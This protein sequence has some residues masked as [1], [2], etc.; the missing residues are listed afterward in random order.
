[1]PARCA[2]TASARTCA[3]CC[4]T[5]RGWIHRRSTCSSA[6]QPT[7]PC[8]EELGENFR[9]IPETAQALLGRANSCGS[10]SICG[11]RRSICFTRRITCCR[12]S[13]RASRSSRFT[14]AS[15]CGFRSTCP[16]RLGY[17]YA[18]SSMWMATHRAN[19]VL[20]VSEASKR[21]ILRYFRVPEKQDRRHLQR[22][23]RA[24]RRDADRRGS[25]ARP[26]ALSAE[27][28]VRALRRATSSRTRTSSG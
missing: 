9:A 1:M 23:R 6:A 16:N 22:D 28:A 11:A 19:R 7:A 8:A 24:V 17:A 13:R 25:R 18:R 3:T 27:R 12:R 26:R 10:R 14:T 2:T 4:G 5:C 15:T 20:T 21:D